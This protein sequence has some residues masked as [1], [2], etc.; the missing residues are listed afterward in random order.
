MPEKAGRELMDAAFGTPF[1]GRCCAIF[2]FDFLFARNK[3]KNLF[4][5]NFI[6]CGEPVR[7]QPA[8]LFVY[9]FQLPLTL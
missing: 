3:Q 1:F 9:F 2:N 4:C 6:F 5:S 7:T 8:L